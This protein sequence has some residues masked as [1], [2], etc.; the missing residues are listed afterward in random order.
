M[1]FVKKIKKILS[2]DLLIRE[3]TIIPTRGASLNEIKEEE[4]FI[5]HPL[6]LPHKALLQI[7]NGIDLDV[8]R[9]YGCGETENTLK[10]LRNNQI[11]LPIAV[12]KGIIIGSDP[13][14][15]LYIED[16][17]GHIGNTRQALLQCNVSIHTV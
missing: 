12:Q 8:V 10:T 4:N 9:F 6:S 17:K 7:W 11:S 13:S 14:G 16:E 5:T 3:L 2:S 15:F 1:D